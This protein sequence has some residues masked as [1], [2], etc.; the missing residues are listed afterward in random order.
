MIDFGI[1]HPLAFAFIGGIVVGLIV[2]F[3]IRK[4]SKFF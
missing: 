3:V 4:A 1:N 2:D